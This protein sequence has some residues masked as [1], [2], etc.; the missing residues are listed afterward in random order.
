VAAQG[1]AGKE[2]RTRED[3][4][5]AAFRAMSVAMME[6]RQG[7]FVEAAQWCH[8]CLAYPDTNE[9]RSAAVHALSAMAVHHLGQRESA[10]SELAQAREFLKVS[11]PPTGF[12]RGDHNGFWFDWAIARILEREAT[13]LI[14]SAAH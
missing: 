5:E 9:A 3:A 4:Y 13:G 6:Y 14:E 11:L 1:L 10:R 8:K 2:I 12:P 7:N